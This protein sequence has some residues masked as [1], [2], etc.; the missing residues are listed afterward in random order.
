[1]SSKPAAAT[2]TASRLFYPFRA[3]GA[4]TDGL[5]F[6]LNRRGDECFLAVSIDR[7][8]Q[9]YRCDHLR[10]VLV[11]P[12][13]SKKI[14]CLESWGNEHTFVG[15]GRE[16]LGW[17][18]LSCTG[19]LGSHPGTVRFL[20]CVGNTL[21]SLC[22]EGRLK[23]WDLKHRPGGKSK[24]P[25]G[26]PQGEGEGVAGKPT[27]DAALEGGFVPTALAHPP[28]YLNKVVVGSEGGALQLWNVRTGRRVHSFQ[29]LD[30]KGAAVSCI[31]PSPA[32]DVAAV[33]LSDGRVQ[34]LNLRTDELLISFKQEVG[35]TS[36]SFRT[37]SA[38][39]ELPLLASA[40]GDGRVCLWDLK[41]RRLHHTMGAH[42]GGISKLQFLPREPVLVS[43]GTDNCIKMWVFDS[44]DGTARLLRSREGHR[45][46]PRA[47]RYYGN[48]TLAT[49]GE[50]AD[51]TALC[52]LSAGTDRSFRVFHTVRDCLSQ[53]LSQKPLVKVATRHRVTTQD[54]FKLRPVLCFA[55]SETRARDWCNIITCHEE[56]SNAYV[57]SYAKR[58]V[59]T[60]V[61]RQKHWPGNAMM[62]PPDPNTFA[63]SVAIS[64]CGNYGLVGT[65]GGHVFRYNM[66]SG[67]PRGSYPQSAT[68]S[69]KA[70]KAL[71]NV[72]KPGSIAKITSDGFSSKRIAAT[73]A[74]AAK[75]RA[76]AKAGSWR[77]HRGAVSGV[78]VDAVNKTM[79]SAG[80][81]GLLVFWA[82]KEKRAD[83]AVAVGSGVSQLE[84][85]RDTEL[86]ALA[87]DDMVV[88]LY[89]LAT[90]K[91]VR[92]LE[93]HT[94]H[95]TDMCFT[96]DARRLVTSSMDHTVRIWDLP[97]GRTVDWMSFKK[98]VT[99]VTVSPTGEFMCTSHHGRVGLSVWADQSFFQPVYLDKIPT[100]PF[101]MD[102]PAPLVEDST[103][104]EGGPGQST[105]ALHGEYRQDKRALRGARASLGGDRGEGWQ[106]E[107]DADPEGAE[108]GGTK[109]I[110]LSSL[111][112]GYWTTL[113]NLEVVKARN[114]PIEPPKKPEAAP[115]FLTT[116]HK[117]G[118]V[119]PSFPEIGT[120]AAAAAVG[121]GKSRVAGA[122]EAVSRG[123][124]V[125]D[126]EDVPDLPSGGGGDAWSD[127][128]D[129]T[130]GNG[131]GAAAAAAASAEGGA[132]VGRKRKLGVGTEEERSSPPA[133]AGADARAVAP[134]SK[135]LK[136]IKSS[137]R[138]GGGGPSRCKL[139]DLLLEGEQ[140]SRAAD[141]M[142]EEDDE[143]EEERGCQKKHPFGAV[144]T[145]LKTLAP[146]MVD[147]E[148][149]LL[150]QGD[151]DEDGVHLV[152]LAVQF[153]LGELRSKRNF[154]VVQAY[155][156]RFLKHY[157][158]LIMTTPDLR[159][160]S[161][162]LRD[163][164]EDSSKRIK[165][166][167]QHSLC[168]V[169]YLSNL[170]S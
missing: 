110:T 145:Y 8:F 169:G 5:P 147:V 6:V 43:S 88:R 19:S 108:A 27:C 135:I 36:L 23:A 101:K 49:M 58:A 66:Q 125:E 167:V 10:V 65:R 133:A 11:S 9:I 154:E 142:D 69:A 132:E 47:V 30:P 28:T 143:E 38:A 82:F 124:G 126:E 109:A 134:K 85:V 157:A 158:D 129:D 140:G 53:E 34:V 25:R 116:V 42:E 92:R 138:F 150:C 84:L 163:E 54:D 44:P 149:S 79:V 137:A 70:V 22:E 153:L 16:V 14:T 152:A 12:P 148:M 107:A 119:A 81:D 41:E 67:Q 99:G 26:G 80:V 35:V 50:G 128:D 122:E 90:R 33:G 83:G 160:A 165:Q 117:G 141:G 139:A 95:L 24:G 60:H 131:E 113:F 144:M 170:Q 68:P 151:W 118:E 136:Q 168:L 52:V 75:V 46:P 31:E 32:L 1:M 48:T 130:D 3:L 73:E 114:R 89:D 93:G 105:T 20:L 156:H 71:T 155:L 74:A 17:R 121:E 29:S 37:D 62:H 87:C 97:T 61:L 64:G 76:G 115:F 103:A 161:K 72:M 159:E 94:N 57:W 127:D 59:G 45:A 4:V 21:V 162:A 98:A 164:Q 7:A 13:M 55:A 63:T 77:G 91:L 104:L 2:T 51:A 106:A 40:G 112:R 146:P 86:V 111:P 78:G 96:P 166:L 120:L 15:S 56:D 39:A 102:E 100:V 123:D 18:R